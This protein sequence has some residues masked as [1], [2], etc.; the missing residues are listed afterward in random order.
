MAK[1]YHLIGICGIGM[2]GI[3][4]LLL[5]R[6]MRVSGSDLKES[7]MSARLRELGA[8]VFIGHAA[9]NIDGA[10]TVIYSSAIKADNP[11]MREAKRRGILTMKRAEALAG[12]MQEGLVITVAGSH[13]KTT[14]ASLVS[15]L[16]LEA[17]L[18]PTIAV[19]GILRNIDTNAYL[20]EGRF[21]VAEADESDG[22]FLYYRPKYSV[23]TN[24]DREHLDY[25]RDME[26]VVDAF[27]EFLN[28]TASD[29]CAFICSDDSNL[30]KIAAGYK[31]RYVSFGL[32][33]GAQVYPKNIELLGLSAQFDCFSGDK[34]VGR[35]AT[36]LGGMHNVSNALALIALGLELKIDPETIKKALLNYK[37]AKRR[38]EIKFDS[39]GYLVIDDYAHHP[40]EIRASLEA[41]KGLKKKRVVAVFQPHRYSRTKLLLEE[42]ARS[43]AAADEVIITDI[44]PAAEAP[45]AGVNGRAL[46]DRLKQYAGGRGVRFLPKEE[47]V[48]HLLELIEPGDLVITLGAGDIVKISE[49]LSE[50]MHA[51]LERNKG[52]ADTERAP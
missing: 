38:L 11:E 37:G 20:G 17:G 25:Y 41:V 23:V 22:S 33:E 15:C 50:K 29:G 31:N 34:F 8:R 6:G 13:G 35:F 36:S 5:K 10:D 40:T 19:G 27:G 45:I 46:C 52:Q 47:I 3:A 14:T 18:S 32:K 48:G 1:H 21:F 42:F 7:R 4:S 26:H 2:S 30:R 44:Y 49:E 16:L 12:L 9:K 43:F 51:V 24:I 39:R 28:N